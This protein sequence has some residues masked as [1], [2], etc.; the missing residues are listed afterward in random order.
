M[1]TT[2]YYVSPERIMQD[3]AE[4]ARKGIARGKSI[5]AM[6]CENGI[7]LVAENPSRSLNKISEI[8]D[9]IAFAGAG[10]YSEYESLRKAGIKHADIKGYSYGREDVTAKSLA[11]AYSQTVGD[12][13]S[14]AVKPLEVEI[15]LAQINDEDDD[16]I[17]R[18]SFDGTLSDEDDFAAIGGRSDE[19]KSFLKDSYSKG[20]T[21]GD[22]LKLSSDAIREVNN[23]D[24]IID[25][26]E[27]AFLDRNRKNR[28]F[29]RVT[30]DELKKLQK[31]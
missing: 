24:V 16:E 2:P 6:E 3:K 23:C 1:M 12:I 8:Y 11:N 30:C 20:M 5:I 27:A 13:F 31:E 10:K 7:L 19:I 15:L 4:Y 25:N 21:L 28:R 17:Y 22:A 18:I 26:L 9:R 29:R 14:Q